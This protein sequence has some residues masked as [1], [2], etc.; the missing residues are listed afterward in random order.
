MNIPIISKWLVGHMVKKYKYQII[1][2]E[3]FKI[4]LSEVGLNLTYKQ[5]NK[6]SQKMSDMTKLKHKKKK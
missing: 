2:I 6:L 4:L 3:D 1:S 5:Q